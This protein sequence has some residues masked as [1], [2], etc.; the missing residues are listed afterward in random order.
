M[1]NKA[2]TELKILKTNKNNKTPIMEIPTEKIIAFLGVIAFC[3][4]GR[5]SFVRLIL[6]SISI[7]KHWLRELAPPP[8]KKRPANTKRKRKGSNNKLPSIM[9]DVAPESNTSSIIF[10]FVN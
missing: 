6:L 7:S 8:V 10:G 2:R 9:I 4:S 3:G 1:V 5:L